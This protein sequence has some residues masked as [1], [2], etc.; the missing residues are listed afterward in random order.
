MKIS[1]ATADDVGDLVELRDNL[2][3]WLLDRGIRQWQPGD[4]PRDHIECDVAAG[5][6]HVVR[7]EEGL[8]AAI[9]ITWTDPVIWSDQVAS[10]GYVHRL[11]VDRRWASNSIGATLLG[12]AESHIRES[13]MTI[14][15]LDCVR[16]N[17][18]LRDYYEMAGYSL[19]GYKDF[20][21][22]A[23]A[24]ETALYEKTLA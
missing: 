10:A 16:S 5:L 21:D 24:L 2:A 15:R 23:L 22:L 18:R 6:V 11:M 14:A 3:R 20:P 13:G 1:T 17:R 9:T 7:H 4:L 8:A 12:W 19:V